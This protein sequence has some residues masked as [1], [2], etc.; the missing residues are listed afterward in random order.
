MHGGIGRVEF[1][2]SHWDCQYATLVFYCLYW[3]LSSLKKHHS[4]FPFQFMRWDPATVMGVAAGRILYLPN[5]SHKLT[6]NIYSKFHFVQVYNWLL[7]SGNILMIDDDIFAPKKSFFNTS[8]KCG[9]K[10][11]LV[12]FTRILHSCKHLQAGS[13]DVLWRYF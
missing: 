11:V 10:N 12:N 8:A 5:I 6:K 4:D 7:F 1:F 13:P 2:Q 9:S 3:T